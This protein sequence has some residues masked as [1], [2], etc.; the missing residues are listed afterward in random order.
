MA[1]AL[2]KASKGGT[3]EGSGFAAFLL[4]FLILS[5][6][7]AGAGAGF[8]F[9]FLPD[10][11]PTAASGRGAPADADMHEPPKTLA[12]HDLP[13]IITNLKAPYDTWIRLEASIIFDPKAVKSPEAT[14]AIMADDI[15]AY[16]G[17]VTLD[18]LQGPLGLIAFRQEIADRVAARSNRQ[19]NEVVLR[20]LVVQ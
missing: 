4:A 1:D 18:Q 12:V 9:K 8:A 7:A 3:K 15:L 2:K 6:M 14:A 17:T 11:G 19:I 10:A 16:L 13:P 5:A 20:T